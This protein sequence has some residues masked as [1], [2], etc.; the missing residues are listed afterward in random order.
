MAIL[1]L[2]IRKY[3]R[4]LALVGAVSILL[5]GCEKDAFEP[6]MGDKPVIY[7][8]CLINAGEPVEA[9]VLRTYRYSDKDAN[10]EN[11]VLTNAVVELYVNGEKK[12]NMVYVNAQPDPNAPTAAIL[13]NYQAQ[14]CPQPGDIIKIVASHPTYGSVEGETEVPLVP[15]IISVFSRKQLRIENQ[16]YSNDYKAEYYSNLYKNEGTLSFRLRDNE[17]TRDFYTLDVLNDSRGQI[18][19]GWQMSGLTFDERKCDPIFQEHISAL[20]K[21]LELR[22]SRMLC[23]DRQFNGKEY[24][25]NLE[26][27]GTLSM[28]G[29]YTNP[30]RNAATRAIYYYSGED[31]EAPE[32]IIQLSGVSR[33][34]YEYIMSIEAGGTFSGGLG[35]IGLADKRFLKSN[36]S[37]GAGFIMARTTKEVRIPNRDLFPA[38]LPKPISN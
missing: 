16:Y 36:L 38:Q 33:S 29:N 9:N 6:N 31:G 19:D 34:Y 23:S 15:E 2:N 4:R 11:T 1:K 10:L 35:E 3:L 7:Y 5:A 20:D 8:L 14:Y 17:A 32:V 25:F 37:T 18:V 30:Q 13:G 12:E 21:A 26:Y 22:S 27:T 24:T 28:F